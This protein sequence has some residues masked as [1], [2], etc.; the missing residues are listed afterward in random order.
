MAEQRRVITV[1]LHRKLYPADKALNNINYFGGNVQLTDTDINTLIEEIPD[2]WNSEKDCLIK[3][4]YFDD[5]TY[6]CQRE[7]EVY[8][9][10]LRQ[11]E[12]KL[13]FFDAATSGQADSLAQYFVAQYGKIKLSKVNNLYDEILNTI[14]D[15]SY[16]KFHLLE[17]RRELLNESDYKMLPDYP[18]SEEEKQRW[19]EFRQQ[20]RDITEQE[21]W[22][23]NNFV[24]V[25]MPTSPDPKNQL[26]GLLQNLSNLTAGGIPPKILDSFHDSLRNIGLENVIKKYSETVLKIEI[27]RGL[28]RLGIPFTTTNEN[29][30]LS[31]ILF[32]ANK[33]AVIFRKMGESFKEHVAEAEI[34]QEPYPTFSS[35]ILTEWQHYILDIDNS[36]DK[37]EQ[38]LALYNI[39]FTI[40]DILE[41]V[42]IH[43]KQKLDEFQKMEQVDELLQDIQMETIYGEYSGFIDKMVDSIES[44]LDDTEEV[45]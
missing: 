28:T 38:Q 2:F 11:T 30:N 36:I 18:L 25:V 4:V 14:S 31:T 27:V 29:N 22:K 26:S 43:T 8:N 3:F 16:I 33:P 32:S 6:M 7:K 10:S 1:N 45:N 17:T 37:I 12:K 39:D 41:E 42:S 9:Y 5:G 44:Q 24:N 13:Y 20:L 35:T 40:G 21:A 23:Q 19:T 34:G 15:F